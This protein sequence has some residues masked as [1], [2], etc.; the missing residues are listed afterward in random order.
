MKTYKTV[1]VLPDSPHLLIYAATKLADYFGLTLH[2]GTSL[3]NSIR[4][5]SH[6]I[7]CAHAL[8]RGTFTI[9]QEE[10]N[11]IF[12][13][14]CPRTILAG[15][16]YYMHHDKL[17]HKPEFP[18]SRT[19]PFANRFVMEDFPFM[20]YW[21]TGY[22]F[23]LDVYAE[24]LVALGFIAMECNRFSRLQPMKPYHWSYAFTNPSPAFFVW[25]PWHNGVWK[26]EL[27][28]ANAR[29]LRT[30][31]NTSVKYGLTPTITTF[32]PRPYP[33]E[34]FDKHP[35]FRGRMFQ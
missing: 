15:V 33:P 8:P 29:E 14:D 19:S 24:N 21:P 1:S 6:N 7:K 11:L 27:I 4:V 17:G 28:E 20:C 12:S 30:V 26:K 2:K 5:E 22:D 25:T 16:L 10:D 9:Y 3:I 13:G 18:I 35:T 23:D 32:L 34:F 31:I